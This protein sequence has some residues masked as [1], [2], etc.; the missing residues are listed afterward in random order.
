MIRMKVFVLCLTIVGLLLLFGAVPAQA[1][2]VDLGYYYEQLSPYGTWAQ[3]DPYGWVWYP[4]NVPPDWRPYTMGRW[5]D[6]DDYGWMWVSDDPW[7]WATDHYG[8]WLLTDDYGWIWIPGYIWGP[9]WVA[10]RSGG[11]YI[12]WAPLPPWV[13][14]DWQFGLT[15]GAYD[16]DDLPW[17]WWSFVGDDDFLDVRLHEH[18]IIAPRNVTLVR[19]TRNVTRIAITD[20]RVINNSVPVRHLE[21]VL[22]RPI[23]PIHVTRASNI[24]ELRM[25]GRDEIRVFQPKIAARPTTVA[26]EQFRVMGKRF[27]SE[28][29]AMQERH[30]AENQFLQREHQRE[31]RSANMTEE[32][33]RK[34][35]E[36]ERNALQEQQQREE[37]ALQT[38]HQ[39]EEREGQPMRSG[40]EEAQPK[41]PEKQAPP[42]EMQRQAPPSGAPGREDAYR[43]PEGEQRGEPEGGRMQQQQGGSEQGRRER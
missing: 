42:Q 10:W 24:A 2:E 28:R 9:A 19:R 26:P 41:Q 21:E 38:R 8:R 31:Q 23:R 35:Q 11:G 22:N 43:G 5:V 40:R 32:Q 36:Q 27:E 7:G 34:Q 30:Q 1:Q 3:Y 4:N 6:T 12:G 29:A 25:G 33:F 14:W 15:L 39:R 37:R 13:G 20:G 16:F 18:I 17:P